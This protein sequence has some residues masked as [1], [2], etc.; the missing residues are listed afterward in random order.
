[1]TAKQMFEAEGYKLHVDDVMFTIYVQDVVWEGQP[2]R[3]A[4]SF[5]KL[6]DLRYT[7]SRIDYGVI[8]SE[9]HCDI[10]LYKA[11]TQQMKELGWI[12]P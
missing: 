10:P 3:L 2:V 6:I 7:V 12:A 5:Y 1:M 4:V 8:Q 9:Y 11:I